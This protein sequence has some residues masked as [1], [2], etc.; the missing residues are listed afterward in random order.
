[1]QDYRDGFAVP[2][3]GW[4]GDG[5]APP[6]QAYPL[7]RLYAK[8]IR[9]VEPIAA[10]LR[11]AGVSISTREGEIA[12]TL[13]LSR[14]LTVI[15]AIIA[16][17]GATGYLVS[18]AASLWANAQRKR[19]ELAVLGL[20]GY[21]PGWLACFPLAQ[22]G[23]IALA[24]SALAIVLFELVAAAINLYF[25]RSIATGESA[26]ALGAPGARRLRARNCRGLARS[27]YNHRPVL[28]PTR[29]Q[30]GVA[31]C[32]EACWRSPCRCLAGGPPRAQPSAPPWPERLYNPQPAEGDLVLPMPCGG[33]MAFRRIDVPAEGVL[34]DRKITLGGHDEQFAYAENSRADYIVGGFTDK[35]K[36]KLRYYYL[37]KYEV[38]AL[39]YDAMNGV[40]PPPNEEGRL[41]KVSVTWAEAV[42]IR[43]EVRRM[44]RQGG[45]EE[46]A[47]RGRER[48][49][50]S[51]C[52]RKRNGSTPRA[53][54]SRSPTPSSFSRPSRC[55]REP[56]ATSGIRAPSPPT[57]S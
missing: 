45:A 54:A 13:A 23:A 36:P 26:C 16:T 30:R 42:A 50:S 5:D 46:A 11:K 43:R 22:S 39:Q 34:D 2:A 24:G 17:L 8:T 28:R 20:V 29:D 35:A 1:M 31:G 55:P 25:S 9:D 18:L 7:F 21:A 57:T 3:L 32:L 53:A 52:R 33:A 51:V 15:L 6:P 41:P 4:T 37:G 49:A 40:C 44:A 38:T 47:E 56:R 48:R 12:G 19:R 27:G 14:N 10:D